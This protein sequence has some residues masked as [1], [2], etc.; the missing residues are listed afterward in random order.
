MS[1]KPNPNASSLREAMKLAQRK[2]ALEPAVPAD[3]SLP[4]E[5]IRLSPFQ[6]RRFFDPTA[7]E[8]LAQ[9]LRQHGMVQP[10]LVRPVEG[11]FE[12]VHGERRLRAARLAGLA[13]V[14][15]VVR[16]LSDQQAAEINLVEN[17]QREDLNPVEE[18]RGVLRLLGLRLGLAESEVVALLGTLREAER[19]KV[20]HNV[21]GENES[22]IIFEVFSSLGRISLG[23]F[24]SHRLPLL[25]LPPEILEVLEQ[26]RLE[27]TKATAIARVKDPDARARLLREALEQ[28]LTLT[29][30]KE[31]ARQLTS[32]PA[33]GP[34]ADLATRLAL[35]SRRLRKVTLS[36][37]KQR[38]V[39]ALLERLLAALEED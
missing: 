5:A 23:S 21:V 29:Q 12:L 10:L 16:E 20:S 6:A 26:G 30:I 9:S 22:S 3:R 27:Y 37:Q 28:G 8:E 11:G 2:A 7:L 35:A 24:V 25:A 15:V 39:D 17:L 31:R 13:E 32:P 18:T 14:P 4:L 1:A 19:G 38:E 33:P 34:K 36:P